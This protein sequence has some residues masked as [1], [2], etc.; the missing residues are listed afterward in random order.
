MKVKKLKMDDNTR[1]GVAFK[2]IPLLQGSKVLSPQNVAEVIKKWMPNTPFTVD[3]K[4]DGLFPGVLTG[5]TSKPTNAAALIVDPSKQYFVE[6]CQELLD[7]FALEVEAVNVV[8]PS[9][10][11]ELV[12]WLT[13]FFNEELNSA[14]ECKESAEEIRE[15]RAERNKWFKSE[16]GKPKQDPL[17]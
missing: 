8:N 5:A 14:R 17:W 13:E 1:P 16:K 10:K 15:Q 9:G 11:Q 7:A 2:F 12:N 4:F 3:S 6:A